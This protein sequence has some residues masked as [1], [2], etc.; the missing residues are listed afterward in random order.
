MGEI[1]PTDAIKPLKALI[2]NAAAP[3]RIEILGVLATIRNDTIDTN[4]LSRSLDIETIRWSAALPS[5]IKEVELDLPLLEATTDLMSSSWNWNL[6]VAYYTVVS[7]I[8]C[9]NSIRAIT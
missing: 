3:A 1:R 4:L 2:R 6:P 5:H 9:T 8:F 7:R